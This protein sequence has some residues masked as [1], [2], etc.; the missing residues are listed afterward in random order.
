MI[1]VFTNYVQP[2]NL[3]NVNSFSKPCKNKYGNV[4]NTKKFIK[5]ISKEKNDLQPIV[6]KKYPI[7]KKIMQFLK[8]QK[9]CVF[10]E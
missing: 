6:E 7:I 3:S 2:K 8:N 4:L 5:L 10:R 9:N 1:V